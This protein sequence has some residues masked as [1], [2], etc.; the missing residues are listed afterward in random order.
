MKKM[1][2][3]EWK[4]YAQTQV[5]EI[6]PYAA[7]D[8]NGTPFVYAE[9]PSTKNDTFN[10]TGD[11]RRIFDQKIGLT[12]GRWEDSLV[13]R[14]G[15]EVRVLEVSVGPIGHN[16]FSDPYI[17]STHDKGCGEYIELSIG[18]GNK[19]EIDPSDWPDLCAAITKMV[20]NCRDS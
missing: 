14:A 2:M 18:Y 16:T 15:N 11:Y 1:T 9:K 4:E 7:V 5:S 19:V 13:E 20:E 6:Y 3:D 17:I 12:D 8:G 10:C